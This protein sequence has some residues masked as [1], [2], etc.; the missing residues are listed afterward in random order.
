[1]K[2]GIHQPSVFSSR[3]IAYC[4]KNSVE[5][6]VVN[7]L[8]NDIIHQLQDCD[9]LMWHYS[10]VD[11]RHKLAAKSI[12]FALEQAGFKVFPDFNTAWH[13]DDKVAQKY[14]LEAIDAPL[15]P[16]Y[17]F[18]DKRT[19]IEW[20]NKT[21]YPKVFK[22]KGGAG[23][24]NVSLVRTR[25]AAIKK[26]NKAF[27]KGFAQFNRVGYIK[28]RYTKMKSGKD[29]LQGVMKSVGRLFIPTEFAKMQGREKGYAYFQEFIE[30][31][32]FDI[33]VVV[34]G[35]NAVALKRLVREN[36]FRASGSGNIVYEN[37]E[38]DKRYIEIAF[39]AAKK[40]KSKSLAIDLIHSKNDEILIVEISYGFPTK[41][42]LEG[43]GGYW[44]SD[45]KWH[46]GGFNP[47][48]W[49]VEQVL[50]EINR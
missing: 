23:A 9:A 34:V 25:Q 11:Y 43:A 39:N 45:I 30:N 48:E 41:N 22:L 40:M 28:E 8:D 35:N 47:Q 5:Y 26:I 29:N 27:G 38:I 3:W 32:G 19:A 20:A 6:K 46:E 33:R 16:S 31:D 37:A 1:M 7:A 36:D 42:F 17:V 10:H 4:K 12:L 21:T 14:L 2:L 24:S 15:V 50:D 44:T 49:M 18:Y 13:F